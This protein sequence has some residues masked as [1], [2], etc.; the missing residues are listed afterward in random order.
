MVAS[1]CMIDRWSLLKDGCCRQVSILVS[2]IIG[3]HVVVIVRWLP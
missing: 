3:K 2:P 1:S